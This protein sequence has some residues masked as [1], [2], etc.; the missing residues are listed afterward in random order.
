MP[1]RLA[2]AGAEAAAGAVVDGA[3]VSGVAS[4]VDAGSVLGVVSAR[5]GLTVADANAG[6]S[7]AAA[8]GPWASAPNPSAPV[9]AIAMTA[10]TIM[11][12]RFIGPDEVR[13]AFTSSSTTG[14]QKQPQGPQHP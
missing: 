8:A 2:A 11:D 12:R 14:E 4:G 9:T 13:L 1:G 6:A 7:V 3:A 5:A 10:V